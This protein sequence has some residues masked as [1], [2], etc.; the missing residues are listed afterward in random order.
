LRFVERVTTPEAFGTSGGKAFSAK[1]FVKIHA[2]HREKFEKANAG[3]IRV[4][5]S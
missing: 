4:R 5:R 1:A 2:D 3:W